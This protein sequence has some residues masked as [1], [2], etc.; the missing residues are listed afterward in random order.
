MEVPH[1]SVESFVKHLLLLSKNE[2]KIPIF[3]LQ[4]DQDSVKSVSQNLAQAADNSEDFSKALVTLYSILVHNHRLAKVTAARDGGK[5]NLQDKKYDQIPEYF[6]KLK[7]QVS[8]CSVVIYCMSGSGNE[9]LRRNLLNMIFTTNISVQDIVNRCKSNKDSALPPL[10]SSSYNEMDD[11]DKKILIHGLCYTAI[12]TKN[13]NLAKVACS[14]DWDMY[15][16][17]IKR[18]DREYT[19]TIVHLAPLISRYLKLCVSLRDKNTEEEK[20]KMQLQTSRQTTVSMILEQMASCVDTTAPV[21]KKKFDKGGDNSIVPD[22][23]YEVFI[24]DKK[25]CGAGLSVSMDIVGAHKF[26]KLMYNN[27]V[28]DI[29]RVTPIA[30]NKLGSEVNLDLDKMSWSERLALTDDIKIQLNKLS[31]SDVSELESVNGMALSWLNDKGDYNMM[32]KKR[33]QSQKRKQP[34]ASATELKRIKTE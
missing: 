24:G 21:H 1:Q 31:G 16:S 26:S 14:V 23:E 4:A 33:K 18:H 2:S 25:F 19:Y 29:I 32:I 15:R 12:L 10:S 5:K 13:S 9:Q 17:Y 28:F 6:Y 20:L 22:R 30:G 7:S 34:S 27:C 8:R 11:A 3:S